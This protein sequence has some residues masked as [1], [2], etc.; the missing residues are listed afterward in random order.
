[1]TQIL[2]A[3]SRRHLN[4]CVALF[5]WDLESINKTIFPED[6]YDKYVKTTETSKHLGLNMRWK[7]EQWNYRNL[8]F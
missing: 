4:L 8:K 6:I 1:M 2:D 7:V 3:P 5:P